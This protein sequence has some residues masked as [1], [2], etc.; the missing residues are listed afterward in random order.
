MRRLRGFKALVHDAV[1]RTTE[2]VALGHESSARS[3]VRALSVA[4]PLAEPVRVVDEI[5]RRSTDG[6]LAT[7]R[8]LNRALESV[9]DA[10]LDVA[11]ATLAVGS[12]PRTPAAPVPMRSDRTRTLRWI[13]DAA[14]GL[15]NGAIGDSLHARDNGLDLGMS[16]R[17]G[18]VYLDLDRASLARQLAAPRAKLAVFVHGLATTEWCWSLDSANAHG[19]PAASFGTLLAAELDYTPIFIRYNSGRHVSEN[20]RLLAAQLQRLVENYPIQVDEIVLI[21]HSMGGLVVRSACYYGQ[22]RAHGEAK[23]AAQTAQGE[24]PQ[25]AAL[26][27]AALRDDAQD[28]APRVEA[29]G[30]APTGEAQGAAPQGEAVAWVDAVRHVFCLGTP[31]RG[32]PLARLGQVAAVLLDA[33]D[34]PG[35]KIPGRLLKGRSAGIKDLRQG[36]LVD[37]DWRGRDPHAL[38]EEAA[39]EI[40]PLDHATYHFVSATVT[41]DREHPLGW[42]IGDLLVRVSSA[43]GPHMSSR[44]YPIATRHYGGVLHHK[45]QNHPAVYRLIRD[46]CA[47]GQGA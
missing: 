35:T 6:V 34:H 22:A 15:V 26:Q 36:L 14:L 44:V 9:T 25:G 29:Q 11:E 19:D 40:P 5:R 18:D 2:L 8:A 4:P 1:E 41:E 16:M 31:H 17:H 13:G 27:G 39:Q 42:L 28:E 43:E 33:I 23:D 10:G 12:G 3:V 45:V 20:G 32:A 7:I 30:A 38:R 24:A 47:V 21:G 37:E 46:A